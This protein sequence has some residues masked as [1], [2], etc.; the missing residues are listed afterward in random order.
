[1]STLADDFRA[2]RD[3][4]RGEHLAA[5]EMHTKRLRW[6]ERKGMVRLRWMSRYHVRIW[7][8]SDARVHMDFWPSAGRARG[9]IRGGCAGSTDGWTA[10]MAA[11]DLPDP[12]TDPQP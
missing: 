8:A 7:R 10:L 1:M 6:M 12:F 4:R 11:L 9:R 3:L 2:L 5:L